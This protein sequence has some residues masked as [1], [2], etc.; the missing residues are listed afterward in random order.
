MILLSKNV[1]QSPVPE[2]V[3]IP[4]F[5]F[6][7]KDLLR[8]LPRQAER[9]R[10]GAQEFNDLRDVIVVFAILGPR[11]WIEKIVARDQLKNLDELA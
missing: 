10:K 1:R 2:T 6:T 9:F 8:P 4:Q 11:L 7:I 5:A 3:D